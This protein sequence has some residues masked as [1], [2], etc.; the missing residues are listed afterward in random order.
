MIQD[1]AVFVY[2]TSETSVNPNLRLNLRQ[3]FMRAFNA[4]ESNGVF[5]FTASGQQFS[6][7]ETS[8]NVIGNE[9]A[10]AVAPT[11]TALWNLPLQSNYAFHIAP[12]DHMDLNGFAF[13]YDNSANPLQGFKTTTDSNGIERYFQNGL[14]VTGLVNISNYSGSIVNLGNGKTNSTITQN[15][16]RV[17]CMYNGISS[18]I[19]KDS[20]TQTWYY[21]SGLDANGRYLSFSDV[22][23]CNCII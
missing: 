8:L 1:R 5:N 4:T 22:R 14:P 21:C 23:Y 12:A 13:Y 7:P 18:V 9:S 19:T 2:S 6:I 20:S 16:S 11:Q 17:Y 3:A 10:V 15:T